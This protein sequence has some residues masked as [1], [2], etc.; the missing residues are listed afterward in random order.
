MKPSREHEELTP[1]HGPSKS[2]FKYLFSR[3][4]LLL[5]VNDILYQ[6]GNLEGRKESRVASVKGVMSQTKFKQLLSSL[7]AAAWI[8]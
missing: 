4:I 5:G 7:T 2:C 3:D 6:T 8:Q 1:L